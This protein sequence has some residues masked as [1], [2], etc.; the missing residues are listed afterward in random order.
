MKKFTI[1]IIAVLVS[2]MMFGQSRLDPSKIEKSV[3]FNVIDDAKSEWVGGSFVSWW[4]NASVGDEFFIVGSNF[5]EVGDQIS[6]IRFYHHLGTVNFTG[7]SSATFTNTSYTVNIY[8]NPTLTEPAGITGAY[9]TN[10]GTPVVTKTVTLTQAESGT[11][12]ELELD[13]PYTV[14]TNT[15]WV[16]VKFNNGLGAM[17]LASTGTSTNEGYF[18]YYSYVD[19]GTPWG[20]YIVDT[21]FGTTGAPSF[22]A[23]GI[24]LFIDDGNPIVEEV[25]LGTWFINN[26]DD[27]DE[28]S[29]ITLEANES[30]ILIPV[31]W[32]YGPDATGLPTTLTATAN[33]EELINLNILSSP[34]DAGRGFLY[35]DPDTEAPYT[36]TAAEL[37]DLGLTGSFNVVLSVPYPDDTDP[38]DNTF[39][40]SVTRHVS[41]P[42]NTTDNVSVFPNPS[43]GEFNVTVADNSVVN[44]VDVTGRIIET[45]VV[46]AG[47]TLNFNQTAGM[48]FIQVESNGK[49]ETHKVIVQ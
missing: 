41:V 31:V 14:T 20:P 10:I 12:Y 37:N 23:L 29:T 17:R 40:L 19:E 13:A 1:I 33:G 8:E 9:E 44:V 48:Y 43:N 46:N 34:L 4:S 42:S 22:R 49:V 28:I 5:T 15:F 47:S 18:M 3:D 27:Q 26:V 45:Q 2:S 36:W 16:S 24:S 25:D 30:L 21:D 39:T 35:S 6:K 38:S 11:N 7:G 32:N